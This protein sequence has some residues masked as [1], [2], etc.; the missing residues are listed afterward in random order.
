MASLQLYKTKGCTIV[1]GDLHIVNIPVSISNGVFYD[2]IKQ[3]KYIRGALHVR[4]NP[5]R[6]SLYPLR[7]I[8]SVTGVVLS[9]NPV[10]LDARL[11]ALTSLPNGVQVEGCDRLCPAR[12]TTAGVPPSDAG[13]TSLAFEY[14]L[15][16]VGDVNRLNSTS[17]GVTL[18]TALWNIT[19]G[20]VSLNN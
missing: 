16:V 5:Y 10:L 8:M 13:C 4:D 19:L 14:Y 6:T 1:V 3:V 17:L 2:A 7:N 9:N 15:Y 20:Q 12:Y 18:A 11:P